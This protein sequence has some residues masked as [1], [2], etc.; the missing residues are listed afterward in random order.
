M[1]PFEIMVS[2]SQ[3]RM[4]C[5]VEPRA[6]RRGARG[7]RAVGDAARPR[8][9]RSPTPGGCGS[10]TAARSVGDMPVVGAG[11]RLPAVRP[12]ARAAPT[13]AAVRRRRRRSLTRRESAG[14]TLLALL[15][16]AQHRLAPRRSSSSTTRSCSRAPCAAPSRPTPRCWRCP[17]GEAIAV[18]IDG[19]GRRVACDPRAGAVEAVLECAANLACVGAEPLGLTNCLNFG[20]PE[21]PHVA[22]Q[23][24]EAVDGLAAGL[25]G[26]RRAGRRR[27]RL[28]LQRGAERAD[29][30]DA[31]DRHGRRA[32][33]PGPRRPARLRRARATRSRWSARSRP[34]LRRLGAGQAARRA[35]SAGRCRRSTW[36]PS[37]RRTSTVR[38]AVRAGALRSAHDIAEGGLAVALAECCI[39]GGLGA[40]VDAAGRAR[41]VRRGARDGRSSS[42]ARPRRSTGLH[43]DRR[44]RRR[45]ARRSTGIARDRSFRAARARART[46]GSCEP[47]LLA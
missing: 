45:R 31:G 4:L 26:A 35:R 19:N 32:A 47:P 43:D 42:P 34:T 12:R 24:T 8:S 28:A 40:A 10:S 33:R 15:A 25:R 18:S 1:E 3:E 5:V 38:E 37:A 14:E 29:L 23:L 9:A 39:A 27:Q 17:T 20:N 30:P 44:R 7:L 36:P 6:R 16:L 11:R 2:E 13:R 41:P 46:G 21:K 22:W